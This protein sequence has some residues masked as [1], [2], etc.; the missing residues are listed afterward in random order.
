VITALSE[1]CV[2]H[3]HTL[4]KGKRSHIYRRTAN[5]FMKAAGMNEKDREQA[6]NR[7]EGAQRLNVTA[8]VYNLN[9]C[10]LAAKSLSFNMCGPL[11]AWWH[12][13]VVLVV[14]ALQSYL[15]VFMPLRIT[16]FTGSILHDRLTPSYHILP[17]TAVA[18][19]RAHR[20]LSQGC[21]PTTRIRH[22]QRRGVLVSDVF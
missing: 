21:Q 18:P 10:P 16:P 7:R 20:S 4:K 12:P 22:H 9:V 3:R 5:I 2:S 8:Q 14:S 17:T 13:T 6:A 15:C 19:H 1:S 11:G